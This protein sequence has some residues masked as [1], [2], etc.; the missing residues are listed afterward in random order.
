MIGLSLVA[1]GFGFPYSEGLP[2]RGVGFSITIEFFNQVARRFIR[3][4]STLP[5]RARVP[6]MRFCA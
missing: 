6:L 3:H 4:Q 1:E 5:L 2:V